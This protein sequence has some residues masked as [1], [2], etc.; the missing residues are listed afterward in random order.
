MSISGVSSSNSA[1]TASAANSQSQSLTTALTSIENQ[2]NLVDLL[3][4]DGNGSSSGDI[5]DLSSAGQDAADQWY[6]LLESVEVG[7]FQISADEASGNVQQKLIS[8]LAQAGIDTSQEIDLQVDSSGNVVVS[9]D[10]SQAQQ[11]E[12]TIND[13][14]DLKKS[15]T[16]YLEFM[17]A[18]A[19]TLEN[20]DN[21]Q[22]DVGSELGQLLSSSS[23]DSQGTV[24]L[25]LMGNGFTTSFSNGSSNPVVLATSQPQ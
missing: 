6:Q 10:N 23:S 5:L 12:N 3:S 4:E 21:D 24:T 13:N 2:P 1:A 20:G 15:V 22:T 9:N 7:K 14:P 16:D 11:I 25:A 18:I 19:P 8:A 17:Q